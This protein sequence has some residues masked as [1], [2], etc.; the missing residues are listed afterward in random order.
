LN[1]YFRKE[2]LFFEKKYKLKINIIP[3]SGLIIPEYKIHL[4]NKNKKII[5]KIENFKTI[6]AK[7]NNIIDIDKSKKNKKK[8]S[9]GLGKVLWTKGKTRLN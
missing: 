3:D 6:A 9:E 1:H 2:I 4:L 7:N 5:K 8:I